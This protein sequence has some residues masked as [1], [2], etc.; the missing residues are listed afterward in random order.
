METLSAFLAPF[1][2]ESTGDRWIT[3]SKG[4]VMR[5]FDVFSVFVHSTLRQTKEGRQAAEP[6]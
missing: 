4:P 5:S 2:G 6:A 3:F 1:W